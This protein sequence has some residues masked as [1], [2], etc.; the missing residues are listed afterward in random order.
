VLNLKVNKYKLPIIE[1]DSILHCYSPVTFYSFISNITVDEIQLIYISR[2][3][4]NDCVGVTIL[5]GTERLINLKSR[6]HF[7]L[8]RISREDIKCGSLLVKGVQLLV[9]FQQNKGIIH[10]L[11]STMQAN[12]CSCHVMYRCAQKTTLFYTWESL[13]RSKKTLLSVGNMES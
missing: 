3:E 1:L 7:S 10:D 4:Q 6:G 2:K 5:S 13:T 12:V 11:S 8:F 9:P